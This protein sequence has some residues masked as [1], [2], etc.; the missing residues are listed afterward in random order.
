LSK[1]LERSIV[2]VGICFLELN[3]DENGCG[4]NLGLARIGHH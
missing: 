4:H 2:F 3:I 1:F